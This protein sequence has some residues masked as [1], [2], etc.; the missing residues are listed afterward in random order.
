MSQKALC[1]RSP[2]NPA[3]GGAPPPSFYLRRRPPPRGPAPAGAVRPR[4]P[5]SPPAPEGGTHGRQCVR[6]GPKRPRRRLTHGGRRRWGREGTEEPGTTKTGELPARPEA[7]PRAESTC[8]KPRLVNGARPAASLPQTPQ[9]SDGC[10]QV[11]PPRH[12]GLGDLPPTR[13]EA[14]AGQSARRAR[15]RGGGASP[16]RAPPLPPRAVL[17]ASA[18]CSPLPVTRPCFP[19]RQG[20]GK[21]PRHSQTASCLLM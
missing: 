16:R 20:P 11:T 21:T 5:S 2:T 19:S 6:K 8:G 13:S 3:E 1:R 7:G 17:A 9:A 10:S 18:V 4:R 12:C 15:L 14:G